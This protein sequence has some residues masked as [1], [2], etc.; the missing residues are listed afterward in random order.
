[1][2]ASIGST[3]NCMLPPYEKLRQAFLSGDMDEARRLQHRCNDAMEAM[4][5]VGLFPAIKY[6]LE[7]Q[8]CSCGNPREPFLPLSEAA[9]SAIDTTCAWLWTD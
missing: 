7:R 4:C 8:G 5:R 1:M 2:R 6:V 9:K 3:F